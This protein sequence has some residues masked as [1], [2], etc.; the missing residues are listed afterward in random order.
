RNELNE[1]CASPTSFVG[2]PV[3]ART[4]GGI[5]GSLIPDR[6]VGPDPQNTW[7]DV[8]SPHISPTRRNRCEEAVKRRKRRIPGAET[9][10]TH[11]SAEKHVAHLRGGRRG[12]GHRAHP[13]RLLRCGL[14]DGV[15]A[16]N[17][18][19]KRPTSRGEVGRKQ[20]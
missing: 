14:R 17:R 9:S 13:V 15:A 2:A 1:N 12:R 10:L 6:P 4:T 11:D 5:A 7:S 8:V 20:K 3:S 16:H 19:G 18:P